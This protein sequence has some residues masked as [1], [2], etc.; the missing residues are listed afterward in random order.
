MLI[1][2]FDNFSMLSISQNIFEKAM[3]E[4]IYWIASF[5]TNVKR[6]SHEWKDMENFRRS[7]PKIY[8]MNTN[9]SAF[10]PI[11]I[12][13]DLC[14]TSCGN[15]WR[16]I[17]AMLMNFC[18]VN[19]PMSDSYFGV[20]SI[21]LFSADFCLWKGKKMNCITK[22]NHLPTPNPPRHPSLLF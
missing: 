16:T 2:Y 9:I 5:Q 15:I 6:V 7:A 8:W 21:L 18:I 14:Q 19:T 4:R 22:S 12:R 13:F 11:Y 1:N 20:K 3:I 10:D 17:R